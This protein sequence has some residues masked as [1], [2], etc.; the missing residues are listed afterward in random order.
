MED[1]DVEGE[2]DPD[3]SSAS[4][5]E[6]VENI[7]VT[8][9]PAPNI[10]HMLVPVDV[11]KEFIPPSL[12]GAPSPPYV[13]DRS[14]QGHSAPRCLQRE[15]SYLKMIVS[16]EWVVLVKLYAMKALWLYRYKCRGG[17]Q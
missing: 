15:L 1:L 4:S 9:V 8:L 16:P 10:I 12:H 6:L 13:E 7:V 5:V 11:P 14:C 3:L 17:L 2:V